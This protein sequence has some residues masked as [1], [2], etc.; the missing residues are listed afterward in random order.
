MLSARHFKGVN[1]KYTGNEIL[2]YNAFLYTMF[3]KKKKPHYLPSDFLSSDEPFE[4]DETVYALLN[5]DMN[6]I[7][8]ELLTIYK[9]II[10]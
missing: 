10:K 1:F 3:T 8:N 7:Y 5:N 2:C 4:Y 9:T 6:G